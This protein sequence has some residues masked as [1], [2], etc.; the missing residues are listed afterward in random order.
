MIEYKGLL[1]P[2]SYA[3]AS[4][5]LKDIICN[6]CGTGGW[7]GAL[8]PETMYGL[9]VTRACN[10]HDWQYSKGRTEC[11][12]EKAD[13]AFHVNM[14]RL[15][16]SGTPWFLIFLLPLRYIRAFGYYQAV[17]IAGDDAFWNGKQKP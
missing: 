11:D 7:K 8:V 9:S 1:A 2:R 5:A 12:K 14:R 4:Q 13:D 15:I 10:I 3:E 17:N 16:R 6:G